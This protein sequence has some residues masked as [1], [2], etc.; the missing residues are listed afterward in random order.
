MEIERIKEL[1]EK[2]KLTKAEKTE[3]RDA[4]VVDGIE[5]SINEKCPDCWRDALTQLYKAAQ[6]SDVDGVLTESGNYRFRGE[7]DAV[8]QPFGIV[9]GACTSDANI[10]R[11][12]A[13]FPS[14]ELF[15]KN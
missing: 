9:L 15:S 14:T 13:A 7:K 12:M 11:Y 6:P 10:E 8:W 2:A 5:V 4:I 1:M 3:I